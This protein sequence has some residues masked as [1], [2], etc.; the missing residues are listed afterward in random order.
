MV[1]RMWDYIDGNINGA[2]TEE[3]CI[4]GPQKINR[5]LY[6]SA[7]LLLSIYL[8]KAKTVTQKDNCTVI[9]IAALYTKAKIWKQH[10]CPSTE[11]WI[12]KM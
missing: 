5:T 11:E 1:A 6:D 4:Q 8:K 12:R 9:F 10:K 2:A 3:N 7:I